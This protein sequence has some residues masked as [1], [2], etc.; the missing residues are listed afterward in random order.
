MKKPRNK[1][2]KSKN[3]V[4]VFIYISWLYI[5]IVIILLLH[6]P[7]CIIIISLH[8]YF[9]FQVLSSL[10]A[11][12]MSYVC[13]VRVQL[14]TKHRV[15]AQCIPVEWLD[16]LSYSK[17]RNKTVTT[18]ISTLFFQFGQF[19]VQRP[20]E[21]MEVLLLWWVLPDISGVSAKSLSLYYAAYNHKI[22]I[23]TWTV[24]R[25]KEVT[26]SR[27]VT[28]HSKCHHRKK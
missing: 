25:V 28:H 8:V 5:P 24:L 26:H 22:S 19:I 10:K 27:V 12:S 9:P 23:H 21:A 3:Y 4:F 2:F 1:S 14:S 7:N 17:M 13:K 18:P 16:D 11:G 6:L 15:C 20:E